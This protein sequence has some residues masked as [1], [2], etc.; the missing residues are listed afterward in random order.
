VE[1]E[2]TVIIC[3]YNRA[4]ILSECLGSLCEQVVPAEHYRILV[5]DNNSTDNT[6]DM[7]TQ[8]M[9]KLTN[10]LYI[11]E[12]RQGLSQARNRGLQEAQTEW[13][14]FLDDD[15]KASPGWMQNVLNTID[16]DDFDCFGGPYIAW[17]RFGPKPT[18]LEEDFGTYLGPGRYGVL[19]E[20][21]IPGGNCAIKKSLA[22][23]AGCFPDTLGM[24]GKKCAYGEET[25]LFL[26]M[27]AAGARI[28]FVPQ[29]KIDHCVLPYKYSL[30]WR[31]LSAYAHGRDGFFVYP[32][33][34]IRAFG[35]TCKVISWLL[36]KKFIWCRR[37]KLPWQRT[38]LEC[39]CPVLSAF[40]GLYRATRLSML[41]WWKQLCP[42]P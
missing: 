30:R 2:I 27:R 37:Q 4:F 15:A 29:M 19:G 34:L 35:R 9:D 16:A 39:F 10:L 21:H 32:C 18:W 28:G 1:A 38:L 8:F 36:P 22:E 3:T 5:V 33:S 14:A 20:F 24:T 17:H 12:P 26:R 40:G 41:F 31:L 13:V 25:L 7:V 6:R 23:A 42:R 11:F